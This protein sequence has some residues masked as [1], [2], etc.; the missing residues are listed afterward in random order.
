MNRSI[1]PAILILSASALAQTH[2]SSIT[3][4]IF[5]QTGK[6]IAGAKVTLVS[7]ETGKSRS[8]TSG[9]AGAFALTQIQPGLYRL[10]SERQGF[11]KT[12]REIDLLVNQ[13]VRI[14]VAMAPGQIQEE[15][16]VT[17]SRGLLK[18]ETS[19]LGSVIE[20]HQ[21]RGLPLDGRNFYDLTLLMPGTAPAAQGSAGSVRGDLALNIN[22]ARE[23]SNN[24]V[25]D[26][27]Y[28]GDPKLNTYGTTP[29]V[30]A[31]QEFEVLTSTYD[32]SF[33]RN[34]GGQ[35][36][37]VLKSGT[38][39]LH[40]TAYEFFR[41][42]ALDARN[43]FAP[44]SEPDPKYQ[45]NQFGGSLGGPLRKDRTF[46]FADYEGRRVREGITRVTNVPTPQ[47]RIGDFSASPFPLFDPFTQR[48]F[49]GNRIPADRLHPIGLGIASLY[50]APN[51]SVAGENFVSSPTLRD[52]NDQFDVRLDHALSEASD[53]TFR[54]SFGDRALFDPF[55]GPAFSL[56][57]GF[58]T[59]I[60]RRSQNVMLGETHVFTPRLLNEVRLGFN[61][62]ALGSFHE[63]AGNSI[64]RRLGLPELSSRA[65]DHGLSFITVPGYSPLGDEYNNPQHSVTNTYQFL[66][67]ATYSSGHHLV[68]FGFDY[69]ALQQN[70]YRNVQSRGFI[71][72]LGLTG[73]ALSELL[74]GLPTVSG[75]ARLD[76]PQ[77][78]RTKSYNFFAQDA[79]RVRP[80]LTVSAGMRYEYNSPGVDTNDRAN[81]YDPQTRQ[82]VPVGR[83]GFPRS[84]YDPDYNNFAPR[85]GIA[86]TPGRRGTVIRAGYGMYYDQ[87]ALAPSEGLYFSPPYFDLKLYYALQTLPLLLHDPF[88]ANYPFP[89]PNS[90]TAFQRDLRT[91]Y[92]QHW[93]FN[94]Q[95][96]LGVGRVVEAAYVGSKGTH[97]WS[98]RDI[99]QSDASPLQPN[100]RPNFQFADINQ[101]ESR[102]N[103][104]YHSLQ[105]RVQQRLRRGLSLLGAYTWSKSIDDASGFFPSAG[106][107]S[108]PQ[109]SNNVRLERGRSGF[110]LAQRL[111]VAYSYD[112]PIARGHKYLSG[113]Q[114]F[115]IL[116]L[117]SGRPFTV[118]LQT[119][120]DNSNTGIGTLGF[121]SNDRPNLVADASLD[122]RT[123]QRWF[124]TSAFAIPNYGSF[125]NAGRNILEGP[126]L[127]TWNASVLKDTRLSE[128]ATLQ[129]RVEAFNLLNRTNFN[130]PDLFVG[131]P[132]F[133][134][135]LSAQNPRHVQL[136]LKLL[137]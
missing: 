25:L 97:L 6:A 103:S 73:N 79:W 86:W 84:G 108:Y 56:V 117:Q 59:S 65:S 34:G 48:P 116:T 7:A 137:F 131:T 74:Q 4:Q 1:L 32:A 126:G 135:I 110:N 69:R 39:R 30:D 35:V 120:F 100:P 62:V 132:T 54:Y 27:V 29:S 119:E 105:L 124:N 89:I 26:G 22:G 88:P 128:S 96:E 64:N 99:N 42:A 91:G 80:D 10:E 49:P 45:R 37:I 21:I 78:L 136:G 47:E 93:N 58:G 102:G 8:V 85:L 46:F 121:G 57:P 75:G 87:S 77:H 40:G 53:L 67:H 134:R 52:R 63:N 90:A 23:D 51:R 125:G 9:T 109:D 19:S 71:R 20:N 123:P 112:L 12:I 115:G 92:M 33:G 38:N 31:I 113:W 50:P 95:Q 76:N 127:A 55:S 130:L 98:G 3:G 83:N 13:E 18:T 94:V 16:T 70:A 60:P 14:D 44:A 5:D 129:F 41:N 107:P 122:N 101:L 15:I 17:A 114:T 133:G 2:R 68:R 61:R 118:A 111:S 28:N 11:R 106:D 66:D 82:L 36:N 72:F 43:Y 81:L 104:N 24:V